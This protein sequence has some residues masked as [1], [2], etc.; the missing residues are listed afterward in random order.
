MPETGPCPAII[1]SSAGGGGDRQRG[2][3]PGMTI[4]LTAC[5]FSLSVML[6][7]SSAE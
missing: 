3:T 1:G 6:L 7:S 5:F 4:C 2:G